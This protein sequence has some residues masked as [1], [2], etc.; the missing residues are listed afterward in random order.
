MN[1]ARWWTGA[2]AWALIGVA[3]LGL[4]VA[5]YALRT[6]RRAK[7]EYFQAGREPSLAYGAL[8]A[9]GGR[10]L[11][12]AGLVFR[13]GALEMTFTVPGPWLEGR[14]PLDLRGADG[15]LVTKLELD[16]PEVEA[17]RIA[18]VSVPGRFGTRPLS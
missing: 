8:V 3:V 13:A 16:L 12:L 18:V 17:G 5:V 9:A 7:R 11:L 15:E 10:Q 2:P 6:A 14:Y 4:A 1:L